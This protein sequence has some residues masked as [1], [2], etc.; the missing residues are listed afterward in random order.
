MFILRKT[1]NQ[2][3]DFK[4]R[5]KP[6]AFFADIFTTVFIVVSVMTG[7]TSLYYFSMDYMPSNFAIGVAVLM[8]VFWDIVK[9]LSTR[10]AI[11]DFIIP[12]LDAGGNYIDR[13]TYLVVLV[14][15]AGSLFLSLSATSATSNSHKIAA[16]EAG[17]ATE[18]Q[19]EHELATVPEGASSRHVYK[20]QQANAAI[21]AA[22][23][24]QDSIKAEERN[25][26]QQQRQEIASLR[27]ENSGNLFYFTIG[28]ELVLLLCT[29]CSI[30]WRVPLNN[31]QTPEQQPEQYPEQQPEQ[32]PAPQPAPQPE[33]VPA[34]AQARKIGF[35]PNKKEDK[36]EEGLL[37]GIVK[38]N[39]KM[40]S[41]QN[42]G[43]PTKY[44]SNK[45]FCSSSCRIEY[46]LTN[47]NK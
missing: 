42:C 44:R 36:K 37:G 8:A 6:L 29:Y 38:D 15:I 27:S 12:P 33:Q 17:L 43:K 2:K 28:L 30:H 10:S 23:A 11:W 26:E 1:E 21:L 5:K 7:A 3:K 35:F 24:K 45:K 14:F 16:L 4:S 34:P 13:P 32:I 20:T 25:R 9:Q 19:P 22:R 41:C 31:R 47:K 18:Q 46:H 40:M 39:I